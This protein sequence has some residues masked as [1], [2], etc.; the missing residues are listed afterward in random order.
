[1]AE[2]SKLDLNDQLKDTIIKNRPNKYVF[3][4]LNCSIII[5]YFI[6][7]IFFLSDIISGKLEPR[8]GSA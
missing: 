3:F 1:M 4:I 2:T 6:T 5:W 8:V 7:N